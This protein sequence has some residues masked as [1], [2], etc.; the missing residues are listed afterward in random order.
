M[1]TFP[2]DIIRKPNV[3]DAIADAMARENAPPDVTLTIPVKTVCELNAHEH[4]RKR[5]RRRDAQHKAVFCAAMQ[6]GVRE[7]LK[8]LFPCRVK[9]TR[10]APGNGLD[11]G[12]NLNSAFK[13]VKDSVCAMIG[14]DDGN[15]DYDWDY[16]QRRGGK[17]EYAVIVEVTRIEGQ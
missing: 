14:T 16:D 2:A 3:A 7:R 10:I 15:S 6:Q 12:D 11:R 1:P 17:G 9:F 4:W 13:H 8:A 5:Q